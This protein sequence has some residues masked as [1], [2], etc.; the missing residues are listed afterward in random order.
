MLLP[1]GKQVRSEYVAG[2]ID[3]GEGD[4]LKVYLNGGHPGKWKDWA[5]PEHHGDLLDLWRM[6]RNLS[7]GEAI[8]QAK[9]YLGINESINPAQRKAYAPAPQKTTV[10]P[11]PGGKSWQWLTGTRKLTTDTLEAFRVHIQTD[12]KAIVFPSFSPTG[13]LVNRSYR[14]LPPPGEKK[15]VWQDAGCAPAMFGWQALPTSA[16]EA[17]TVLLS[18]G[19]I[20]CMTWHQWG[21]PALSI[22][23]GSGQTWIEYEWD[24]LQAFE[25]LL[26]AFDMDG[27]GREMAERAV[28]RLGSHRCQ[29]VSIPHKDANEA[30]QAGAT[31]AD[32]QQWVADA[33]APQFSGLVTAADLEKR[34]LA[35]MRPRPKPF[36]MPF[37]DKKW[38]DDGLFFRDGELTIWTGAYGNGKSTFLNALT[39]GILQQG[40]SAFLASMEAKAEVL[41]RKISTGFLVS[42]GCYLTNSGTFRDSSG[43]EFSAEESFQGFLQAAGERLV[44]ADVV[45]YIERERLLEMMLFAFRKYNCRHYFIDSMMRIEGLEEDYPA[46]G[47]FM[48]RLQ[49]F[50]KDTGTHVHLVSHPRKTEKGMRPSGLDLKGSSLQANNADQIVAVIRNHEKMELMKEGRDLTED[51]RKM[52]DTEIVVDK[53]RDN[54]WVGSFFFKFD[55]RD[56]TF[57]PCSRYEKPKPDKPKYQSP[58]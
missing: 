13:Q 44:F 39:V 5:T 25:T 53:Q 41:L 15:K 9:D 46:Q 28:K 55:R 16:Y 37:F 6:A 43:Q 56:F 21:I 47:K 40:Q 36:T 3:G 10:A 32:A 38:P 4:S 24:N 54:G 26:I 12:P 48:N 34:L 19:Q 58:Y 14:T 8:Q 33:K 1:G 7:P 52:H 49:E 57:T 30:L 23:S 31:A 2:S 11:A 50:A 22:P 45:G 35:D 27:A 29:I 20:D 17:R 42:I 51:E 18:E